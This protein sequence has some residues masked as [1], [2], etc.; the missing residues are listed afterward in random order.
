MANPCA[1]ID[2]GTTYSGIAVMNPA[3]K[4]E[5]IPNAEGERITRSAVFFQDTPPVIVGGMAARAIGA[6]GDRVVVN[7]KRQMGNKDFSYQI[8]NRSYSPEEISAIILRK[9]KQDA[10]ER[11][12][13]IKYAVITVP[14]Y[15][16]EDQRVATVNAAK[17]AGI[18]VLRIINEPTAAAIAYASLS[19]Q[20][21]T[22]LMYDFGGGTFDVSIVRINSISDIEVIAT[23]GDSHLGGNDLDEKL[24]LYWDE[25]FYSEKGISPKTDSST[26]ND[27]LE[28]AER[29]KRDL[30]Q[31]VNAT[32]ML[33]WVGAQ[34]MN[35]EIS[36]KKFV[37]LIGDEIT[38]TK[39]LTENVLDEAHLKP[40]DI[41]EVI[42]VGGSTRIPAVQE[43]LRSKFNKE[44]VRT[45][46]PDEVVALG[47]SIQAGVIMTERGLAD[48]SNDA[49][50]QMKRTRIR[51]VTAHSMGTLAV[52]DFDGVQRLRNDI[53]IPKN[54]PIPVT[55]TKI[56]Y[57]IHDG[58]ESVKCEVTQGDEEDPEW[59]GYKAEGILPLPPGRPAGQ[60]VEVSY[61]Y[62]SNGML[63]CNFT[64]IESGKTLPLQLQSDFARDSEERLQNIDTDFDNLE[65]K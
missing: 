29:A 1:G 28:K 40:V 54:T 43:M 4:P 53:I 57:T 2:L 15:F 59:V 16:K 60:Q 21:G 62:D 22:V 19:G 37:E 12:G 26:W 55:K 36:R 7:V 38:R 3:G 50:A 20:S 41:D 13:P 48:L 56:Y 25:L 23:D 6:Y 45:V 63:R 49:E 30:S 46:N 8:D 39:M 17:L 14:A 34:S 18:K 11:L 58:Q 35:V 42:L 44:P 32:Q 65:I 61:S 9:V 51:D 47:A 27:F 52:V 33:T 64:D 10:E 31:L 24:A 5:I